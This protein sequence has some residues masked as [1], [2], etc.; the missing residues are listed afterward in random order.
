MWNRKKTGNPCFG[1]EGKIRKNYKC[2]HKFPFPSLLPKIDTI[3]F[4]KLLIS[5]ATF[6]V[7]KVMTMVPTKAQLLW[8]EKHLETP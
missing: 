3:I 2:V 4:L 8:L 7:Y 1:P 6:F 5:K